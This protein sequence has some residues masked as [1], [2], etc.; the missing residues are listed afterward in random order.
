MVFI[1]EPF[2]PGGNAAIFGGDFRDDARIQEN[3]SSRQFS[4]VARR[5]ATSGALGRKLLTCAAEHRWT[6]VDERRGY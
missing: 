5:R 3:S 1:L 4:R 6:R 2:N